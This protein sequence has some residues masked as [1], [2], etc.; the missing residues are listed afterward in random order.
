MSVVVLACSFL[1]FLGGLN[2]SDL[3]KL[4]NSVVDT[5]KP[6]IIQDLDV[7]HLKVN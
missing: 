5:I 4:Q 1:F 7:D 3:S 2:P 6:E